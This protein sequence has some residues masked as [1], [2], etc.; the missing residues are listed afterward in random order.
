MKILLHAVICC[1][2]LA[3]TSSSWAQEP[4]AEGCK[5]SAVIT[6]MAGS[7]IASCDN[8][9]YDQLTVSL[10]D[11]AAGNATQKPSKA[12]GTRGT[13]RLATA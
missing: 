7:H 1:A 10:P 9:E 13:T 2:L 12:N 4:D 11:D 3:V 5:D 8:K 6:R